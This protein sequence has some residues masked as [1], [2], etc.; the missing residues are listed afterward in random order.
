MRAVRDGGDATMLRLPDVGLL[1][2]SH[3]LMQDK[4]NLQVA[5]LIWEWIYKH[6]E[7]GDE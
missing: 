2:N 6:V 3:I 1:G 7:R 5:G 4:N